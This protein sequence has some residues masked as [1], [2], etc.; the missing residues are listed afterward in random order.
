M[1]TTTATGTA[2]IIIPTTST[3]TTMLL[4]NNRPELMDSEPITAGLQSLFR[5]RMFVTLAFETFYGN[6]RLESR[7]TLAGLELRRNIAGVT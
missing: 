5:S 6:S 3:K 7:A 2:S 4:D 1:A